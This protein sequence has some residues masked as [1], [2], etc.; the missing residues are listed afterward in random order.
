M[1]PI[2]LRIQK[3]LSLVLIVM[4][5]LLQLF[6]VMNGVLLAEDSPAIRLQEPSA[7]VEKFE[8]S[9]SLSASNP[10]TT[11]KP[12]NLENYRKFTNFALIDFTNSLARIF[13]KTAGSPE[14]K[15]TRDQFVALY[16]VG[17]FPL[18]ISAEQYFADHDKD[19][20][21][22]LAI[23]EYLPARR[24]LVAHADYRK[25]TEA[26][27][28]G[29]EYPNGEKPSANTVETPGISITHDKQRLFL[30]SFEIDAR[31]KQ[32]AAS[33]G[34]YSGTGENGKPE[35]Y[36]RE[37]NRIEPPRSLIPPK[38]SDATKLLEKFAAELGGTVVAQPGKLP[39]VS[40]SNGKSIPP[41]HWPPH[42]RPPYLKD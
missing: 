17:K 32:F 10:Q 5:A 12:I 31:V 35:I 24:E 3:S 14:G 33:I 13:I 4:Y 42:L 27:I 40:D 7:S 19:R 15:I 37:R 9:G 29:E 25:I 26:F 39:V 8:N 22:Q 21:G 30:T 2:M 38:L 18:S 36:D 20:D 6:P 28:R 23:S 34:G 11:R 16:E 1:Q 41:L